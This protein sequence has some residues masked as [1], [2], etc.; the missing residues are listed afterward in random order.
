MDT[1]A[2]MEDFFGFLAERLT[3]ENNASDIL[4]AAFKSSDAFR[5]VVLDCLGIPSEAVVEITREWTIGSSRPDVLLQVR[6]GS[7]VL[8]EVKL[9]DKD[10]HY[11]EYSQLPIEGP[12]PRIVLLTAHKPWQELPGWDVIQ[13]KDLI[14]KAE[15]SGDHFTLALARYFRR[16]TMTKKL[17][18][19]SFGRPRGMLYLNRALERVILDY[20][21]NDFVTRINRGAKD[22][23]G[24]VSSGYC[25]ELC[26]RSEPKRRAFPY[27][28]LHYDDTVEGIEMA[29]RKDMHPTNYANVFKAL[30]EHYGERLKTEGGWCYVMML[31]QDFETLLACGDLEE[32]MRILRNFFEQFNRVI[33]PCI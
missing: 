32:Q 17:E 21:S 13:W 25:Y 29:L 10:Y 12:Q 20:Q 4:Y 22:S 30:S 5:S 3:L 9:F 8:A 24:E 18:A 28:C 26:H 11:D 27:F 19:V 16:V 14:K 31:T 6:D 23:F 15:K 33:E 7:D 1:L 2:C